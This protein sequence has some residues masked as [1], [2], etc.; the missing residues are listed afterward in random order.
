MGKD[1]ENFIKMAKR[2]LEECPE[3]MEM[4]DNVKSKDVNEAVNSFNIFQSYKVGGEFKV[5]LSSEGTDVP[6][7]WESYLFKGKGVYENA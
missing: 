2:S 7:L 5:K 4:I 6:L 1:L 3:A